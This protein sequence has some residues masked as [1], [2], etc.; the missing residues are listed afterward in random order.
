V[1][2][3]R[4]DA[5]AASRPQAG[6]AVNEDAFL[7]LRG[8]PTVA[9]LCDGAGHAE[10]AARRALRLFERLVKDVPSSDLGLFTTWSSWVKLLDSAL[11]GGAESTF[12]AAAILDGRLVGACVG[13]S[14][15]YQLSRE[16]ELRLLSEGAAKARL[17]S[18]ECR[19]FP[20]HVALAAGDW[21]L[22]LSD[23]AWAPLGMARLR[24]VLAAGLARD[25]ADLPGSILDAAGRGGRGDDMTAV[26]LRLRG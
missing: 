22:L 5:Y 9:A 10:R 19:P 4:C 13:D 18:G 25:A 11:L 12:L 8:D 2:S 17:G 6:R 3:L 15:A 24:A 1:S 14:R 26:A 23:G 20:L 21:V 7:I 16:G